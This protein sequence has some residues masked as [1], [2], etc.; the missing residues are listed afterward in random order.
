MQKSNYKPIPK[1][2]VQFVGGNEHKLKKKLQN[3]W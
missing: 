1:E 2:D 3:D